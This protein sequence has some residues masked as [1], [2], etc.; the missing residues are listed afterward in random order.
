MSWNALDIGFMT[1]PRAETIFVIP[2]IKSSRPPP[3]F[4][5]LSMSFRA[6]LIASMASPIPFEAEVQRPVASLKSPMIIPKVSAHPEATDSLRVP[7]S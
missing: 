6:L 2:E 3:S 4:Q 7:T 5:P 1:L